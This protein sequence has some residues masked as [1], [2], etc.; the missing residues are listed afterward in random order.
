MKNEFEAFCDRASNAGAMVAGELGDC[1]ESLASAYCSAIR[2]VMG[3][4]ATLMLEHRDIPYAEET[5][6][7][8]RRVANDTGS[9][10]SAINSLA[11][12][13]KTTGI[14]I[15]AS[16]GKIHLSEKCGRAVIKSLLTSD[17]EIPLAPVYFNSIPS[18]WIS[19]LYERLLGLTP[20]QSDR[21]PKVELRQDTKGRKKSGSFFTPPYIIGHIITNSL[22]RIDNPS[23]S[24]ILD[25]SMGPG[26]FLIRALGYLARKCSV[27]EAAEN[28][29]FGCDIDPIAV[30]IARFLLWLESG[31]Q[32]DAK[33]IAKHLVCVDALRAENLRWNEALSG[34]DAVIGNPPY[35][36]SKNGMSADNRAVRGQSD[37]YLMFLESVIENRLVPS[38]IKPLPWVSRID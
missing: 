36:A 8:L 22:G 30:D 26:D 2:F 31:G 28:C 37:Y 13:G 7:E 14:N 27:K 32:A 10:E 24:K 19:R 17:D 38:G 4:I 6:I 12:L 16:A 15:L 1:S 18:N 9:W 35:I 25:P 21:P 33:A 29:I 3:I 20:E 11:V 23:A 5:C 34:F